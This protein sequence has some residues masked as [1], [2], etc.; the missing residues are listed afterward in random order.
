MSIQSDVVIILIMEI[1]KCKQM[2]LLGRVIIPLLM[3]LPLLLTKFRLNYSELAEAKDLVFLACLPPV[4][5]YA[6]FFAYRISFTAGRTR[7]Y[8]A[9]YAVL[10]VLTL[11]I[12][13]HT[14]EDLSSSIHLFCAYGSFA[15]FQLIIFSHS[16]RRPDVIRFYTAAL[17]TSFMLCMMTGTINAGAE[18]VCGAAIAAVLEA[19]AE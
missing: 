11:I 3:A 6:L 5:L 10:F 8:F 9:A 12:P 7:I 16:F 18:L 2:R 4:L 15:V 19:L 13:Y 14:A 1:N 17:F